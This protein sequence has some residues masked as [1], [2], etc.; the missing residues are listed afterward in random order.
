MPL[1][2]RSTLKFTL[3]SDRALTAFD[4]GAK[5][6]AVVRVEYSSFVEALAER[7]MALPMMRLFN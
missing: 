7:S 6:F 2:G 1:W 4:R 5:Q 3:E